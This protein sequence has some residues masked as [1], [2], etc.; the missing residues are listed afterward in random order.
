MPSRFE[1]CG[2]TQLYGLRY[3][4]VPV[5]ARTG[6][7]ADSVIDANDA[8]RATGVAT[9]IV[10]DPID[11]AGLARALTR[12]F[13]LFS[14][15]EA[16]RGLVRNGMRQPVGWPRSAALYRDLYAELVASR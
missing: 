16:W 15:R 2:L 9:G 1:P 12:A 6:G 11:E 4:T 7:L 8:A 13:T 3:G 14:E 5:V 10:F